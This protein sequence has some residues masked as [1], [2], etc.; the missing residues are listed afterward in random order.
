MTPTRSVYLFSASMRTCSCVKQFSLSMLT[1]LINEYSIT[2][3]PAGKPENQIV[4]IALTWALG[5][6]LRSTLAFQL[7]APASRKGRLAAAAHSGWIGLQHF[8]YRDGAIGRCPQIGVPVTSATDLIR[9][10]QNVVLLQSTYRGRRYFVVFSFEFC[11]L[12]FGVQSKP[13][14]LQKLSRIFG[15]GNDF[16]VFD[17]VSYYFINVLKQRPE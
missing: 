14:R 2:H 16:P 8:A 17:A 9:R 12:H 3:R 6:H 7:P 15:N 1:S 5:I 11:C 13:L 4:P 10:E